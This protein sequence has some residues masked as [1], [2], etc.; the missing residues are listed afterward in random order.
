M[1]ES[2]RK[3]NLARIIY[4]AYPHTDLLTINP[5]KDCLSLE[6]LRAKV[7]REN[8]GDGLFEFMVVEIIEG[9]ESTLDGAIRVLERA[10]A[11][12]DAVLHALCI[13]KYQYT[14][15]WKCYDCGRVVECSYDHLVDVGNPV[16]PDCDADMNVI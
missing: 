13:T 10:K 14:R 16:C 2:K 4:D 12:V 9:G 5:E 3:I 11:D 8:I 7:T 6:T 15:K 1:N